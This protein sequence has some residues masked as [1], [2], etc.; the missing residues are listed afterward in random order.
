MPIPHPIYPDHTPPHIVEMETVGLKKPPWS[1]QH[2]HRR[3]RVNK[4]IS[5]TII[6]WPF[7]K[8]SCNPR[9]DSSIRELT[10][11]RTH[12]LYHAQSYTYSTPSYTLPYLTHTI[13][14]LTYRPISNP[15]VDLSVRE[16]TS[17]RLVQSA[18]WPVLDSVLRDFVRPPVDQQ[19]Y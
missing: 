16:L 9:F 14:Y 1:T 10:S 19:P 17:P 18:N 7:R 3:N 2:R 4:A 13:L 15:R 6:S 11:P 8:S 12:N 5:I